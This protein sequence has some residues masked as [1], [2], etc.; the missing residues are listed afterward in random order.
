MLN[1]AIF[2]LPEDDHVGD[3]T[4]AKLFQVMQKIEKVFSQ[5]QYDKVH[6]S[7]FYYDYIGLLGTMQNQTFFSSKQHKT[8]LGFMSKASG[9]GRAAPE[10]PASRNTA[11]DTKDISRLESE[12]KKLQ[13]E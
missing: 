11:K 4:T 10:A 6:D 1:E 13:E 8:L 12:N 3:K 5:E 9:D 7:N 2:N